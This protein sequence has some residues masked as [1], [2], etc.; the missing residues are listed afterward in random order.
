VKYARILAAVASEPWAIDPVKGR[1]IA[2]FLAFAAAGG[3]YSDEQR[4]E[5]IGAPQAR[6]IREKSGSTAVIALHGV[7]SQR[8]SMLEQSSGGCAS[9]DVRQ[10]VNAAAADDSV[11]CIMLHVDSP[12]GSLYGTA[13]LAAAIRAARDSKPVVAMV[14]SVAASAAYWAASQ[15]TEICMTPGGDVGS[16]GVYSMHEDL[17][18]ALEAEGVKTTFVFAGEHKVDGNPF[19][20]LSEAAKEQIQSRVDAAYADFVAAVASGRG[21]STKDVETNYGQGRT[22]SAK[23][24][25]AAGMVD[26]I[27]TFDDTLAR[28]SRPGNSNQTYARR[29]RVA[30]IKAAI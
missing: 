15:A 4:A 5:K 20:P 29:A 17:S 19:E 16:I 10:A 28:Y 25:L 18:K 8:I 12:G 2:R 22:F 1:V 6:N 7:M 24:A 13:E 11:K 9:D 21:V 26:R 30:E 3:V 14:D 27:A 23:D